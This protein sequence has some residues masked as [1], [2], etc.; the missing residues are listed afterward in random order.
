MENQEIKKLPFWDIVARSFKYVFKNRILLKSILPLVAAL[1]VLQI[2]IGLPFLCSLDTNACSNDWRRAVT[3]LSIA[4]GAV[5][6]I[7]NYCRSIICKAKVDFTSLRFWKQTV[8]YFIASLVLS[9]IV[10]V[11]VLVCLTLSAFV[12]DPNTSINILTLISVLVSVASAIVFAP[13]FLVFPAI[14]VEDYQMIKWSKL[15][16]LVKGNHNAVFWAQFVIMLPYWLVAK[17]WSA[18]Y[19]LINS[20]SYVIALI[21]VIGGL[22]LGILD[23]C[24]KGAFFAHVYQFFKFYDKPK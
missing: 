11:P 22:L 16:A 15:F 8:L 18:I 6:V 9:V 24:F 4:L 21:F 14:A 5:S 10:V 12:F 7:I 20:G 2:V 17:M 19:A 13:L 23:A 3:V 1:A